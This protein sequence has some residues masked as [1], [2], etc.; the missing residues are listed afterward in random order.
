MC[1]NK[2]L[3]GPHALCGP[4]RDSATPTPLI[5]SFIQGPKAPRRR[6]GG[7]PHS[8]CPP[9]LLGLAFLPPNAFKQ[10]SPLLC[11]KESQE[12]LPFCQHG[13]NWPKSAKSDLDSG[14]LSPHAAPPASGRGLLLFSIGGPAT[15]FS[16]SRELSAGL[17]GPS[18]TPGF[19]QGRLRAASMVR[20]L[21]SSLQKGQGQG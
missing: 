10:A 18:E 14:H 12:A 21:K 19:A 15:S 6:G 13:F 9:R 4:G 17:G 2:H 16:S 5:H 7:F 8:H 3:P 11:R 20:F 1:M